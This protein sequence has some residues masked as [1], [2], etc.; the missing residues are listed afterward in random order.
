M[1]KFKETPR[2]GKMRVL[3]CLQLCVYLAP[4]RE[5]KESDKIFTFVLLSLYFGAAKQVRNIF[6]SQLTVRGQIRKV[7]GSGAS[8]GVVKRC[9]GFGVRTLMGPAIK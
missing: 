9:K 6:I 2:C 7:P 1:G 8:R 4:W 5:S 3:F